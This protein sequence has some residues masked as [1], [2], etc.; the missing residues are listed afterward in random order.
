MIVRHCPLSNAIDKFLTLRLS[1]CKRADI[2]KLR[3]ILSFLRAR[4]KACVGQIIR[5]HYNYGE[6]SNTGLF[7][8]LSSNFSVFFLPLAFKIHPTASSE[9]CRRARNINETTTVLL[10]STNKSEA[11]KGLSL[12]R[13]NQER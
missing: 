6:P 1:S 2:C 12:K 3:C 8:P 4:K 11:L 9:H 13:K 7:I 10:R 5:S